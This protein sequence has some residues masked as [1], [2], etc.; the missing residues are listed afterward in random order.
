MKRFIL[1]SSGLVLAACSVNACSA[2]PEDAFYPCDPNA[3]IPDPRCIKQL[4]SGPDAGTDAD[5]ESDAAPVQNA[6]DNPGLDTSGWA[7][8]DGCKT[9]QCLP[10][11]VGSEAGLWSTVPISLWIGPLDQIP[12]KCPDDPEFGVPSEKFRLFDGLVAPPA[13]CSPCSCGPSE[14]T[15][16]GVPA[17]LELRAGTCDQSGVV[18]VPFDALANWDGACTNADTMAAGAKCP[19]GSQTLCAQSVHT[20]ELP[21]PV[22][23]CKPSVSAPAAI[24]DASWQIG[25][26]ACT[27]NTMPQNCG[28]DS[29][30]M[31]CVN[32]PGPA[33]LQCTFREGIYDTCPDNYQYARHVF[34]PGE[35]IDDRGCSA[36]ECGTP[37]GSACLGGLRLSSAGSCGSDLVTLQVGSMGPICYDFLAPGKAIGSKAIVNRE[38]L[39]GV[40]A[41][42]GGEAVGTAAPDATKAI[43]FCCMGPWVDVDPPR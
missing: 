23:A 20:S 8:P 1:V 22:D 10:T 39:P 41:A 17:T 28:S 11:P 18:T 42:S 6:I 19:A 5:A 27:G 35:P 9:G 3:I 25:A 24:L 40:C 14:G 43:T 38:Y 13:T 34:Y 33:W 30:Q 12:S 26:L 36:C 37:S 32:D 21:A 15:C 7:S 2:V 4:L 31:Y 16:S 29:L